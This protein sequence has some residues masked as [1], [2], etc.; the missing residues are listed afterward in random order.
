M[1]PSCLWTNPRVWPAA[2]SREV[3]RRGLQQSQPLRWFL[4]MLLSV[5]AGNRTTISFTDC[6]G[7]SLTE[8]GI[9]EVEW[10]EEKNPN[11]KTLGS[12][13]LAGFFFPQGFK[14]LFD[15]SLICFASKGLMFSL[16]QNRVDVLLKARTVLLLA[17]TK[18]GSSSSLPIY[19][20]IIPQ[21]LREYG[22]L[23]TVTCF[24]TLSLDPIYILYLN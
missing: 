19:L 2:H 4:L 7:S 12:R 3:C 6:F 23:L 22:F 11:I 1:P 5:W 10:K 16:A 24:A 9:S 17:P 13:Y 20:L 15:I 8:S 14:E 18:T 21:I